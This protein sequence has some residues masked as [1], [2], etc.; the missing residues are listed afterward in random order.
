MSIEEDIMSEEAFNELIDNFEVVEKI[1]M[2][3]RKSIK[4]YVKKMQAEREQYKKRIQELEEYISI[5]PNLDKMT[6]TE[7]VNI[8]REAYVK[9]RAEE[10]QKAEEIINNYYIPKQRIKDLIKN[11]TINISGFECIALENLQELLEGEK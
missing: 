11:E 6:A 2:F 8:Q 10:Q 1:T 3:G 9:G 4:Y 7:Y 5:A